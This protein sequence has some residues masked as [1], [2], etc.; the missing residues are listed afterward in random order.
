MKGF[1]KQVF[2][3]QPGCCAFREVNRQR[4]KREKNGEVKTE[5]K[6]KTERNG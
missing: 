6:R 5:N 3:S 4:A 2:Q 1:F